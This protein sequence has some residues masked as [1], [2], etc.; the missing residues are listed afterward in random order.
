MKNIFFKLASFVVLISLFSSCVD[1]DF[2]EPQS[3]LTTYN[4]TPTIS[5]QQVA[6]AATTT[7]VLYTADDIIEAYVTSSDEEGN[8]YKSISFQ[9]I[10]TDGSN[11]IGF[12][13][14]INETTLFGKGFNPGRKIYIK[15]NG[16]YTA[17]V[18]GSLQI[19]SLYEGTIGRISESQWKNHLFPSA[20]IVSENSFVRTMTLSQ[21]FAD[22]NQNTLIELDPVQFDDSSLNRTYYDVDS[23]GGATNHTIVSTSGGTGRILR[24]SSFAPF[25]GKMVP[26]GSGKIRG[27][28][29]KYDSD[30]QFMVRYESDIKLTNARADVFPPIG[31]SAITYPAT[32][33]ET[34]ES[35]S[36]TSNGATFP[37]YINDAV[38]GSRYWDVKSFSNN[39]YAQMSAFGATG[40]IKAYLIIPVN[41][42]PGYKLSFKTKDGFNNGNVLKVYYST[43]YVPGGDVSQASKTNIT[44]NFSIASGTTSGYATNFTNSGDY[45]IPSGLSGNGF[46]LFEYT[47]NGAGGV[48][49]TM[50]IDDVKIIP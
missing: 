46:I 37:M 35:Y 21:T 43:N 30:F 44:G 45:V 5:V 40:A 17:Y 47:G 3:T 10:P 22:A 16:L 29:T 42:T 15:L 19:G 49:T 2:N 14:P 25:S 24:I 28:L 7:P 34:F 12:S 31:G 13:V 33:T 41:F 18:Y 4:F 39:K 11:P 1:E 36:T 26:N 32:F 23:G 9:T 20:T 48:T 8:F 38:I 50:Q 27:V 6:T